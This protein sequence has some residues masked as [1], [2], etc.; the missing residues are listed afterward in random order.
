MLHRVVLVRTDVSEECLSSIIRVTRIGEL[1]TLAETSNRI[2]LRRN[3]ISTAFF[4]SIWLQGWI[5]FQS[6]YF[7]RRK[8][9]IRY[10][11]QSFLRRSQSISLSCNSST[12]TKPPQIQYHVETAWKWHTIRSERIFLCVL[13]LISKT[14]HNT[15]LP[16]TPNLPNSLFG[17]PIK[18]LNVPISS[19]PPWTLLCY[20]LWVINTTNWFGIH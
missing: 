6:V 3:T 15:T 10:Q 2:T 8:L 1:G 14:H 4:I 16:F 19:V 7:C 5:L 12:F 17:Y 20:C 13:P 9:I 18:T 11:G